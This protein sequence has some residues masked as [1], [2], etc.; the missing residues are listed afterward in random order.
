MKVQDICRDFEKWPDSWKGESRDKEYGE[1]ICMEMKPFIEALIEKGLTKATIRR[2][3]DYLWLLG[4]EIIRE[5]N[6]HRDY[7]KDPRQKILEMVDQ[8]GGP[9]CHHISESESVAFDGTCRK[10]WKFL[11]K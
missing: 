1:R 8:D 4:G 5:V 7:K 11:S 10:F 6:M 2:H 9:L 3:M